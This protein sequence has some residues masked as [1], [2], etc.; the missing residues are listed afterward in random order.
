VLAASC[1]A[2]ARSWAAAELSRDAA[3]R[4]RAPRTRSAGSAG[5]DFRPERRVFRSRAASTPACA[6]RKPACVPS[7]K[8]SARSRANRRCC[9]STPS[10][11]RSTE[12][13]TASA[14]PV[15][16]QPASSCSPRTEAEN[17]THA[18]PAVTPVS[19][20]WQAALTLARTQRT[21]D[22]QP[23]HAHSRALPWAPALAPER[24]A[25]RGSARS[26]ARPRSNSP[27]AVLD[28]R[29]V[30]SGAFVWLARGTTR[31]TYVPKACQKSRPP[32]VFAGQCRALR[33]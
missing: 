18:M 25:A 3:A 4:R 27:A 1:M 2:A 10:A 17:S 29:G 12:S 19:H 7:C 32:A 22:E 11:V 20:A 16:L 9:S 33:G 28:L 14:V 8:A 5:S 21:P 15:G 26:R 23:N 30:S 24:G 31:A 6:A 13:V